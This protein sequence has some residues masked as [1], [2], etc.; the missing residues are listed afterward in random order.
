LK[1]SSKN[2]MTLA[3]PIFL[4]PNIKMTVLCLFGAF[5]DSI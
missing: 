2:K 3:F 5:Q 4:R 1:E